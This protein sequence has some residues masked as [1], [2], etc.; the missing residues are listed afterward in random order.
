MKSW[1]IFL[2]A[3]TLFAGFLRFYKISD[4]PHGLY[5]DEVSIGYN[6]YTILHT[7]KDEY[8]VSYPLFFKAFGEYKM[9]VY[10]YL[11]SLSMAIFGKTE[12]AVR[13][14]SALFGTAII[15]LL[16]LFVKSLLTLD[17][18]RFSDR[19]KESMALLASFLLAITPW[20]IQ[21]S[22]AGFEANVALFLFLFGIYLFVL[23]YH[24]Y[25]VR[26]LIFGSMLIILTM[27]TY[28]SF[29][30]L[31][32]INLF[33]F[34]GLIFHN[35]YIKRKAVLVTIGLSFLL[36]LPVILFSLSPEGM[37]RF[38]GSSAFSQYQQDNFFQKIMLYPLLYFQNYISY[39]SFPFLFV[40]GDG[41]GRHSIREVG[42]LFRWELPF[43]LI[44]FYYL[45]KNWKN[46]SMKVTA[47]LLLLSPLT[48]ALTIP[49]PHLLRSLPL[50]VPLTILVAL[51][52]WMILF[53]N[54]HHLWKISFMFLL[55]IFAAFEFFQYLHVY[56]IHYPM[57]T[58]LDWGGE[59][60]QV[61]DQ[62]T[63]MQKN[64]SHIVINTDT[65]LNSIPEF[66]KFYNDKLSYMPV[67]NAWHKP[68]DWKG[69]VLYIAR[70]EN[71][72]LQ[73]IPHKHITE[74]RLPNLNQDIYAQFWEI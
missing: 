70:N 60:K 1:V 30:L 64:Y 32:P 21:F 47:F 18:K 20:H 39:F 67:G 24:S 3:I 7:G 22:R 37:S 49:S 8:G 51:G 15:P 73:S 33:G 35:S 28:N 4:I 50:V 55:V 42:P 62:A 46:N 58:A 63:R 38:A 26:F 13:F 36:I 19:S 41:I 45:V 31:A 14:S 34:Y 17:K 66:I 59:Y 74:I 23:Y 29:R 69:Q 10:I 53:Y 44:G 11:T 9:P 25:R 48:A 68:A 72:Y 27:Y 54:T 65:E 40:G 71:T 61:V 43:L 57:L 52:V 12:F 16:Y 5:S 6:A 56:Y 2:I